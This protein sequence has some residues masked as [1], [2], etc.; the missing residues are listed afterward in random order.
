MAR[1]HD[2]ECCVVCCVAAG[3]I[4]AISWGAVSR[5]AVTAKPMQQ[6]WAI[7]QCDGTIHLGLC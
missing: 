5:P 1:T 7:L 4:I 6:T 2:A 3:V